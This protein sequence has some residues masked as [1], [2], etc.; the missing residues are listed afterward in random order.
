MRGQ[1]I[2]GLFTFNTNNGLIQ[3]SVKLIIE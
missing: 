1:I 3:K 2:F